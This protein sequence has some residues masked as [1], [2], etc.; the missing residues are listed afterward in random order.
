MTIPQSAAPT[1]PFAQG[2]LTEAGE[3]ALRSATI[4]RVI[5]HRNFS[6]GAGNCS[7]FAFFKDGTACHINGFDDS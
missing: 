4:Q 7:G 2:S 3:K 1:A 5:F 6:T